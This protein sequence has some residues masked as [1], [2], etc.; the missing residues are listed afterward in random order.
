MA[1]SYDQ[2]PAYLESHPWFAP[3]VLAARHRYGWP[4]AARTSLPSAEGLADELLADA[5]FR[6]LKLGTWLGAP[7]GQLISDAV[8]GVIPPEYQ[9]VFSLTVDP[10]RLAAQ[11]QTREEQSKLPPETKRRQEHDR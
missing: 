8:S 10:L 7:D 1:P 3:H 5:G 2:I 4:L 6:A 9:P 11:R